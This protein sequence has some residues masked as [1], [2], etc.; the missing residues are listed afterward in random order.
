MNETLTAE[1]GPLLSE[2]RV[3]NSRAKGN[4]YAGIFLV[5][6]G[7]IAV[8]AGFALSGEGMLPICGGFGLLFALGGAYTIWQSRSEQDLA[9]R[10]YRDGL[11][12]SRRGK[13][14][15][16][17]WDE[18][19]KVFMSLI[20]NQKLRLMNYNYRLENENGRKI[21]FNYND[22]TLQN[23]QQ[24]SDTIQ[25]EITNRQLPA[26]IALYNGGSTVTFGPLSL[27]KNG[28]SNGKETI[29]WP[30]V[31]EV[32]LQNGAVTV[33]KKDKWLNWSSVTV[34]STPNIY[35]FLHL[36]DQIIGLK[37]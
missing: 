32:K 29:P 20:N 34:G 36:V 8:I 7:L 14:E 25:R 13:S 6:S 18:M 35:V 31:E 12:Y 33:R 4:Y 2:H 24:L 37:K 27:S 23:M 17:R 16:M 28:L 30:E 10:T 9:I 21:T 26:A 11:T 3:T 5:V 15:A 19:D 22:Q 1:L